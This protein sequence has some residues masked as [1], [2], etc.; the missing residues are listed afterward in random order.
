MDY[1]YSKLSSDLLN[2]TL[3][4]RYNSL[5]SPDS[6]YFMQIAVL[7]RDG[8]DDLY[9]CIKENSIYKWVLL[10][11][12]KSINNTSNYEYEVYVGNN[13]IESNII[14]ELFFGDGI[15]FCK[16]GGETKHYFH[17]FA[18]DGD[19]SKY[20]YTDDLGTLLIINTLNNSYQC[21][22]NSFDANNILVASGNGNQYVDSGVSIK[23]ILQEILD[24]K[25]LT[26][27]VQ[28]EL[29]LKQ[30]KLTK[31][32]LEAVNSGI[33]SDKVNQ[34]TTNTDEV[35]RIQATNWIVKNG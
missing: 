19:T 11:K 29:A 9:I 27:R 8:V 22:K 1:I 35:N 2:H 34:I 30:D 14:E 7:N 23:D 17:L 28:E 26:E 13:L 16:Y 3:W 21:V 12:D 20:T 25:I 10:A 33:T 31:S 32:Q 18:Y 5:P 4:V 24:N 15:A 6:R